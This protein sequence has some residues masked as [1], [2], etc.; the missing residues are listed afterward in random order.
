MAVP[1]NPSTYKD[2]P[3]GK[4]K[5]CGLS[6]YERRAGVWHHT[7]GLENGK[8]Y[9]MCTFAND[10]YDFQTIAEPIETKIC[11]NCGL[12]LVEHPEYVCKDGT[13]AY[14]H[15]DVNGGDICYFGC[16]YA[17]L[18][19]QKSYK[20]FEGKYASFGDYSF[21]HSNIISRTEYLQSIQPK[22]ES[23]KPIK[24]KPKHVCT[25]KDCGNTMTD[26]S[27]CVVT[28]EQETNGRK[29]KTEFSS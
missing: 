23:T 2:K 8:G 27:I 12:E 5:H 29:F 28:V 24:P 25:C 10:S 26:V 17:L 20:G 9:G 11:L 22:T 6:I 16:E 18:H 14:A 13:P 21:K 3:Q 15:I 1:I 7:L 19:H 4:C